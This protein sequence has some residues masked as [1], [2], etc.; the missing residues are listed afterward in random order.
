MDV[1]L[2]GW[3]SATMCVHIIASYIFVRWCNIIL[4][5]FSQ[6]FWCTP[7]IEIKQTFTSL[8]HIWYE[9]LCQKIIISQQQVS[10]FKNWSDLA[11][12]GKHSVWFSA[13]WGTN[14]VKNIFLIHQWGCMGSSV[15]EG[16]LVIL[17]GPRFRLFVVIRYQPD[18]PHPP[19]NVS[20]KDFRLW[21]GFLLIKEIN[22]GRL[23]SITF[24]LVKLW[25]KKY[26]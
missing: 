23:F 3:N 6:C 21:K 17:L 25:G 11:F 18:I 12:F 26:K 7:D 1:I 8:K 20:T 5:Y 10:K 22:T 9:N 4:F 24:F 14:E 2:Y 16:F 19:C 13:G 15:H